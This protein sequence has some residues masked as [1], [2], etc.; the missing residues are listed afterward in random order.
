MG[1][2]AFVN[3]RQ[4]SDPVPRL[5]RHAVNASD[6]IVREQLLLVHALEGIQAQEI[7]V[8]LVWISRLERADLLTDRDL[9]WDG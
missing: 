4:S 2:V 6:L 9:P 1:A 5:V 3:V 8:P 7:Q